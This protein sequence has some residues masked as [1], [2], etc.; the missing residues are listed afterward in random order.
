MTIPIVTIELTGSQTLVEK[1]ERLKE[2]QKQG[3]TKE[4]WERMVELV[5]T[6]AREKAPFW[7]GHGELKASIDEEV[8]TIGDD[9]AGTVFS[10]RFYAP[11]QERGTEPYFPNL[12]NLEEWAIDHGVSAWTVALAIATR[13]IIPLRFFEETLLEEENEIVDLV[14]E[15][16]AKI[17][18]AKY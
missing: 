12:D 5:G 14:G 2:L 11:F 9:I 4:A 7:P 18:E 13:G 15:V 8:G 17:M 6:T 16:I 10:D 1:L 3:R